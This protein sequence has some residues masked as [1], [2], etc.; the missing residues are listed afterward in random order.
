M[1]W[2]FIRKIVIY[3]ASKQESERAEQNRG[4]NDS[5][6]SRLD[7]KNKRTRIMNFKLRNVLQI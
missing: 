5:I 2:V 4:P 7:T 6:E 1:K 3:A